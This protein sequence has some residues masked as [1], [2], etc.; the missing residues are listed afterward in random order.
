MPRACDIVHQCPGCGRSIRGPAFKRHV[1]RCAVQRCPLCGWQGK[2]GEFRLH[3]IICGRKN[4]YDLRSLP[5]WD[6]GGRA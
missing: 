4:Q 2:G 1:D 3:G 5:G 6:E